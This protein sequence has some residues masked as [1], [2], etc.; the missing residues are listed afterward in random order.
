MF[1]T[2]T[3]YSNLLLQNELKEEGL[4]SGGNV[5]KTLRLSDPCLLLSEAT[6]AV[7][8]SAEVST[9]VESSAE[10]STA[11]VSSAEVSSAVQSSASYKATT[12]AAA[13]PPLIK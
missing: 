6:A 11:E 13:S 7:E 10:V 12:T 4:G 2:C 9:A 3:N 8:S 5:V 1:I